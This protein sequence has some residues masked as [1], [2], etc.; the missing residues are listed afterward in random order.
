MVK[1]TL[2]LDSDSL[3]VGQVGESRFDE[4]GK[5]IAEMSVSVSLHVV[6]IRVRDQSTVHPCP[7]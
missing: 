6:V 7:C 1:L 4:F 5:V 3:R 2:I